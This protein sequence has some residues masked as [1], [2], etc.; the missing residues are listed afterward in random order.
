MS[1]VIVKPATITFDTARRACDLAAEVSQLQRRTDRLEE[2]CGNMVATLAITRN[3]DKILA[4]DKEAAQS[5]ITMA[6]A[7]KRRFESIVGPFHTPLP[8]ETA[9]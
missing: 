8:Q 1:S 2:L 7:W 6:D 3:R 9:E 4:G 5:L